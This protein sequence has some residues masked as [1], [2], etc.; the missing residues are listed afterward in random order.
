VTTYGRRSGGAGLTAAQEA[1]LDALDYDDWFTDQVNFMASIVPTLTT[2]LPLKPGQI[3]LGQNMAAVTNDGLAE[4]GAMSAPNATGRN[5]SNAIFHTCNTGAWAI[6]IRGQLL[7]PTAGRAAQLGISRADGTQLLVV[8]T[9]HAVSAT[10][11]IMHVVGAGATDVVTDGSSPGSSAVL[12]DLGWH[13]F[14]FTKTPGAGT[15]RLHIDQVL[16]ASTTTL[17]N[18]VD[19][20]MYLYLLNTILNDSKMA[21]AAYGFITP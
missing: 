13:D 10:N 17:T 14:V 8:E 20:A 21:R 4:G 2:F 5:L 9:R 7:G 15:L 18:V 16:A 12:A 11:Y 6:A 19:Q 1:K 3:P